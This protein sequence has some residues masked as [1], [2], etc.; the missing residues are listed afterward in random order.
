[1]RHHRA[2]PKECS[3]ADL[4]SRS[5]SETPHSLQSTEELRLKRAMTETAEE[6]YL[7]GWDEGVEGGGD[8]EGEVEG[9]KAPRRPV[10]VCRVRGVEEC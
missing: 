2:T 3:R 8:G 9:E 4:A 6:G 1:M 10:E 5:N 7:R